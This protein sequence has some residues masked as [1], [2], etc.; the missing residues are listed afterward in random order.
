MSNKYHILEININNIKLNK[1]E[2]NDYVNKRKDTL[3][4][5]FPYKK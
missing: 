4:K 5:M 2:N 3:N 1:F